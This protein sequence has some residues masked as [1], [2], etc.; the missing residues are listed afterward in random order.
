VA[1]E[2]RLSSSLYLRTARREPFWIALYNLF[3]ARI[4][5]SS[6]RLHGSIVQKKRLKT[7]H[8]GGGNPILDVKLFHPARVRRSSDEPVC[9]LHIT[10]AVRR[11]LCC[12]VDVKGGIN[13]VS[14]SFVG[15]RKVA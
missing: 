6:T 4:E 8:T 11:V 3:R 15:A 7:S 14:I 5:I 1:G 10:G 2:P 13:V 9:K 12:H